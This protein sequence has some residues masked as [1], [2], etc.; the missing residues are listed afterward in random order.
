MT[1]LCI[2]LTFNGPALLPSIFTLPLPAR[3]HLLYKQSSQKPP[4]STNK[5]ILIT[6]KFSMSKIIESSLFVCLIYMWLL[7]PI[8]VCGVL[9]QIHLKKRSTNYFFF[10]LISPKFFTYL[11]LHFPYSLLSYLVFLPTLFL[12]K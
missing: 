10:F 2:Y 6:R 12:R 8:V 3:N 7:T 11:H 1:F 5:W 4:T 9:V